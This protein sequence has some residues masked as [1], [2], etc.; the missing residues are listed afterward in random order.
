MSYDIT[1]QVI[2]RRNQAEARLQ[3]EIEDEG[4]LAFLRR[5][6]DAPDI[7]VTDWEAQ[8]AADLTEHPRSLTQRQREC[9]DKLRREYEHRLP[10]ESRVK[11][12][13]PNSEL[14][15]LRSSATAEDGRTP[16]FITRAAAGGCEYVVKSEGAQLVECGVPATMK[17]GR[18][19]LYCDA[20]AHIVQTDCK[21]KNVPLTLTPIPASKL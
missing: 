4:R 1:N 2:N 13:T 19:L 12:R 14:S 15:T 20:H 6:N 21:R 16:N 17:S 9:V 18:G 10:A 11:F 3:V 7:N 8:F 5:L